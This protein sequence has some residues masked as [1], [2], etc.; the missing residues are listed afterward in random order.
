MIRE[1]EA[2]R[3]GYEFNK[4]NRRIF[5]AIKEA[6]LNS[7]EYKKARDAYAKDAD[8]YTSQGLKVP[9]SLK[10]KTVD[11]MIIEIPDLYFPRPVATTDGKGYTFY[12]MTPEDIKLYWELTN[13]VDV[14]F[15]KS[16]HTDRYYHAMCSYIF[17]K[18]YLKSLG[19]NIFINN[20]VFDEFQK[21]KEKI[22]N[23]LTEYRKLPPIVYGMNNKEKNH[24]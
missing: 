23:L 7:D 6:F 18:D 8:A 1:V 10:R 9:R 17:P 13:E 5:K 19:N 3:I 2:A 16:I 24:D 11:Y 12:K 21:E 20:P 15:S 22:Q 14:K 4:I